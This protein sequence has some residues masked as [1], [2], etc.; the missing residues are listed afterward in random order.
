MTEGRINLEFSEA[1][2]QSKISHILRGIVYVNQLK[3][4]QIEICHKDEFVFKTDSF[5]SKHGFWFFSHNI[6]IIN[7]KF[8]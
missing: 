6:N 7:N 5:N 3:T 2:N 8:F 1:K 4:N